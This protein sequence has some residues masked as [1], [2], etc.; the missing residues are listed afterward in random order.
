MTKE[1]L[2]VRE[3][4]QLFGATLNRKPTIPST[5][6]KS[7]RLKLIIE[8]GVVE[9]TEAF[10]NN[11]IAAIADALGDLKYVTEGAAICCGIDLDVVFQ[12]IHRSNMTKLWKPSELNQ[13]PNGCHFELVKGKG[14]HRN[15][16][17]YAVKRHDGKIIKSPSY[18]KADS[19]KFF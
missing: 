7:L 13:L 8:E 12:E 15:S 17:C 9:L 6:D 14:V 1:A 18:E 3:W 5:K 10:L 4:H 11:D 16:R 2:Q 19:K